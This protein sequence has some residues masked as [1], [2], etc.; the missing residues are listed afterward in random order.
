ML[1]MLVNSAKVLFVILG[2]AALQPVSL[3]NQAAESEKPADR[4]PEKKL[5]L[6][7]DPLPDGALARMGTV[8]WRHPAPITFV[9]FTGKG[10][11]LLTASTDGL[12]RVWDV[13]TGKEL[14]R[15]GQAP[16]QAG[17]PG[18]VAVQA[19]AL[20]GRMVWGGVAGGTLALSPDGEVLAAPGAG[21][22]HLWSV[23]DGKELR[24]LAVGNNPAIP[25]M[26]FGVNGLAF[27]ADGKSIAARGF[28]QS[29]HVWEVASGK[30]TIKISNQP[31]GGLNGV[32]FI[33]GATGGRPLAFTADRSAVISAGVVYENQKITG[34]IRVNEVATA[35][36]LREIKLPFNNGNA[37]SI[38]IAPDG[39][40]SAWALT[41]GTIR[42]YENEAGKELGQLGPH[43][44]PGFMNGLVYSP[45]GKTLASRRTNN[46]GI[47]LWD[48]V[49]RKELRVLGPTAEANVAAGNV[50]VGGGFGGYGASTGFAFSPDGTKVAEATA[51]N[52]IRLWNV[53]DGKEVTTASA[54]KGHHGSV[55]QLVVA[56]KELLTTGTDGSVRRW[57]LGSGKELGHIR[58]PADAAGTTLSADGKNVFCS[59]NANK[60]RVVATD[61]GNELRVFDLPAP[62]QGFVRY[63]AGTKLALS[64][65][66][67]L[68]AIRGYNQA[69]RIFD[70][71]GGK[72]VHDLSEQTPG[73]NPNGAV[74]VST[75]GFGGLGTMAFSPN[76]R[77]LAVAGGNAGAVM[78]GGGVAIGGAGQPAVSNS[79]QLHDFAQGKRTRHFDSRPAAILDMAFAPDSRSI[80]TVNSDNMVS[81]WESLTG[82]ECLQIKLG[83]AEPPGAEKAIANVMVNR[84]FMYGG[85]GATRCVAL[86]PDGRTVAVASEQV[87]R[88]WDLRTGKELGKFQ[89]HGG[90]VTSLAFAADSKTLISGSADTTAL[91]WDAGRF[92]KSDD[93]M[94]ELSRQQ[95]AEL[96]KDL[97]GDPIKAY[98]AIIALR[99]VPQ[100]AVGLFG[101]RLKPAAGVDAKHID[102]LIS[103]LE[104]AEY[105]TRQKA[106]DELEKLGELAGPALRQA[107]SNGASLEMR[108]RLDSLLEK[109][110][111]DKV[112]PPDVL[113]SLRAILI[114]QDV[115]TPESR[116]VLQTLAQGAP[117]HRLTRLAQA[118]LNSTR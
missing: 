8:R 80:V 61:T 116:R 65:D 108:R 85:M 91:V 69:V 71:A 44:L 5:D 25:G 59:T 64:P 9:G 98:Q 7:G 13:D 78:G 30:E 52:S 58:L 62:Q 99:R 14:R 56:G 114:L 4:A 70:A 45:E 96:W 34:V 24:T 115:G 110:V 90:Q 37:M 76:G 101:G 16:K 6:F 19:A 46:P 3:A 11:Q 57:D 93:Q 104:K 23:S 72:L 12:Y 31:P 88:L 103:D 97:A 84:R 67:K 55:S 15:L 42:F 77:Q 50:V 48:A 18:P 47:T 2:I 112:P 118:A 87:I 54:S 73:P 41:D 28:D 63:G 51:G 113:R 100:Q 81:I 83:S 94:P 17:N 89:G 38:A 53:A 102:Q 35:K 95:V 117:G 10:K 82:K 39:K 49:A 66:G 92:I 109:I 32:A 21:G 107:I 27:S 1:S 22:I 26:A 36:Q 60:V 111:N 86:A 43:K 105:K 33:G 106:M 29:I 79:I 40:T 75:A 20:N 74:F 68:L